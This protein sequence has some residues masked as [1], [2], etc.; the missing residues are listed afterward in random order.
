MA[1]G[2]KVQ[3]LMRALKLGGPALGLG[4]GGAA[5]GYSISQGKSKKKL[6]NLGTKATTVIRGQQRLI[7]ALASQNQ[8]LATAYR[9]IASGSG[10]K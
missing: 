4:A 1:G 9:R 6:K 8:Q 2:S 10:G 7:K 5:A 3:T